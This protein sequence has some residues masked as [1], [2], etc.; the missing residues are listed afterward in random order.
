MVIV[1]W[2]VGFVIVYTCFDWLALPEVVWILGL[3]CSLLVGWLVM[4]LSGCG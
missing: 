4:L 3:A 1:I 2:A